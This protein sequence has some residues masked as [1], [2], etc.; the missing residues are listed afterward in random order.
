MT[1]T[2]FIAEMRKRAWSMDDIQESL[3]EHDEQE[4]EQ[5]QAL[6]YELFLVA[7]PAQDMRTYKFRENGTWEDL[8]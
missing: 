3:N 8:S 6:P 4:R 7:N 2:D 5:G 1:R